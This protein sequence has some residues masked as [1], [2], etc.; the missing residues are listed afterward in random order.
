M[1]A[2]IQFI[3]NC[4]I[5]VSSD[6]EVVQPPASRRALHRRAAE[7]NGYD[8]PVVMDMA[9]LGRGNVLVANLDHDSAKRPGNFDGEN[10]GRHSQ[11]PWH[12]IGGDPGTGLSREFRQAGYVWQASVEAA[13]KNMKRR[14]GK[15]VQVNGRISPPGPIYITRKVHLKV[16]V[17]EPRCGRSNTVA[18]AAQKRKKM[19]AANF[20]SWAAECGLDRP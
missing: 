16:F 5:P 20:N 4:R 9:G 2:P 7:V 8:Q 10:D 18:I 14:T 11:S 1:P 15:T 19:Q 17:R 3:A 13:P 6:G 12:R